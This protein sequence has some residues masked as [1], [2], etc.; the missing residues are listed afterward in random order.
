MRWFGASGHERHVRKFLTGILQTDLP[1]PNATAQSG[2]IN[3]LLIS[4]FDTPLTNLSYSNLQTINYLY[5]IYERI[6]SVV[7]YQGFDLSKTDNIGLL[8]SIVDFESYNI[9]TTVSLSSELA[10]IFKNYR[11]P[12]ISTYIT[13]LYEKSNNG[14]SDK[15]QKL[16]RGIVNTPYLSAETQNTLSFLTEDL[17]TVEVNVSQDTQKGISEFFDKKQSDNM[18]DFNLVSQL[19]PFVY[20]DNVNLWLQ[21]NM[22]GNI[23][24]KQNL[25]NYFKVSSSLNINTYNKKIT[26]YEKSTTF[27]KAGDKL[28]NRPIVNF[29]ILSEDINYPITQTLKEFYNNRNPTI[30]RIEK[31]CI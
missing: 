30:K 22:G 1:S 29:D 17:P 10:S 21:E 31:K 27:D 9:N 8:Q 4:A 3:R 26:N 20:S 12:N 6:M 14:T 18:Y 7:Q 5:E 23:T 24:T 15:F 28:Y 2:D 11:I 16:V 25:P 13:L 19:P